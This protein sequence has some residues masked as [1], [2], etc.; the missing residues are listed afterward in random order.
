MRVQILKTDERLGVKAG[1]VYEAHRY[2]LDPDKMTLDGRVPDGYDPS[3]NLYLHEV[4][5]WLGGK[6]HKIEGY[7][8]V[9]VD[10]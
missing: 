7:Q 8:Y 1:E 3:C 9:P 4:L 6:W 5:Y 2:G 10:A